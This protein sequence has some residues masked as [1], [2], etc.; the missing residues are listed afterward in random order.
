MNCREVEEELTTSHRA[1]AD[2]LTELVRVHLEECERCCQIARIVHLCTAEVQLE[3]AQTE[4]LQR[5][6]LTNLRPARQMLP[7]WVFLLAFAIA[8]GGFSYLG[9]S[10]LGPSGWFMLMPI[11][12][13]A[14]FA[15]LAASA[16]LLSFS[17]VRQMA[18]G[19]KS[20]LR[21]GVL[22]IALFVLLSLVLASVFQVRADPGF[23]RSGETCLRAGLPFAIPAAFVF[24]LILRRGA[25]LSPRRLGAM[26]GMLA[27]LVGTTVLE[28]HCG[29]LDIWHILVWHVGIVLLGMITGLLLAE[30][31][32]AIRRRAA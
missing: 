12:R 10:Y 17:L 23:L 16:A 7:F 21:P 4:R 32:A 6:L 31:A 13:I 26:T 14:V 25:I 27:G 5:S 2:R 20:F 9:V 11:Q 22:P 8:F 28:V 19:Q 29:N 1:C 3:S 15:T 24:W 18:P 30:A